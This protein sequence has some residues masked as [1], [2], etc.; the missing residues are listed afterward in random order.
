MAVKI[1]IDGNITSGDKAV[2]SVFDRGFLYGDSIYEVMRTAN[3]VPVDLV[4]H[5]RAPSGRVTR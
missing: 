3:G 4:A 5:R 2:V 1:W